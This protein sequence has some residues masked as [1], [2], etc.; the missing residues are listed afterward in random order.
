MKRGFD[1]YLEAALQI[2]II[3]VNSESLLDHLGYKCEPFDLLETC[4]KLGSQYIWLNMMKMTRILVGR[5]HGCMWYTSIRWRDP[6]SCGEGSK[7]CWKRILKK[8]WMPKLLN[9]WSRHWLRR[10]LNGLEYDGKELEKATFFIWC[11]QIII[12]FKKTIDCLP[13]QILLT[14]SF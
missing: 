4:F 11:R 8:G 12:V 6:W 13:L 14:Y 3:N 1:W 10:H 7:I 5:C 2:T 9:N